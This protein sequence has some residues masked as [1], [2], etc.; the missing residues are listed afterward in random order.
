[1]GWELDIKQIDRNHFPLGQVFAVKTWALVL[2]SML[3]N[4]Y[5]LA[6]LADGKQQS[7]ET[8]KKTGLTVTDMSDTFAN[9][10]VRSSESDVYQTTVDDYDHNYDQRYDNRYDSHYD[11][12]DDDSNHNRFRRYKPISPTSVKRVPGEPHR[13]KSQ[14]GSMF[15]PVA[16][17]SV[18]KTKTKKPPRSSSTY[19][20]RQGGPSKW[21]ILMTCFAPERHI[22]AP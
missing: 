12:Y 17:Y 11:H 6:P 22:I 4:A 21:L 20:K 10:S 5:F 14:P 8:K 1:M 16:A 9:E 19:R 3:F 2:A 15:V 18:T 13:R 7:Y